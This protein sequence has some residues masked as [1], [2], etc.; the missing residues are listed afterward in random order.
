MNITRTIKN[1]MFI[2]VV[3]L[4]MVVPVLAVSYVGG[5]APLGRDYSWYLAEGSTAWG[6]S[7]YITIANPNLTSVTASVTYMDPN[8]GSGKGDLAG[9]FI[10]LPPSS[11]T[12]VDPRWDL[13]DTDFSTMV[14]CTGSPIAVDRTMTWTGE[15]S[16]TGEGHNSIAATA[17]SGDWYLPEGSSAWGFETWTLVQNPNDTEANVELTY[18]TDAAWKKVRRT[19]P[20]YSR[21]TYPMLT[22]IGEAD[23][24]TQVTSDLPVIV[25]RSMYRND[26]REGSCSIG[27]TTAASDYFL[28]EGTTA[29]GF[30]TYVLVQNPNNT[31]ATVGITYMTPYG[32]AAQPDFVMPPSTRRTVRVNDAAGLSN[33][34]LSTHV[35]ADMPIVAERAMYWRGGPD[36]GEACHASIG[37]PMGSKSF[38]L[39]DGQTSDGHETYTLVQNPGA[40][41]VP[42][43]IT[44]LPEGG[45]TPITFADTV[46]AA[47]RRTYDMADKLQDGRASIQVSVNGGVGDIIAERS[48]YW[49]SRGA[50]DDTVGID[51]LGTRAWPDPPAGCPYFT[52][53]YVLPQSQSVQQL[54]E[55]MSSEHMEY[56]LDGWFFF[57]SLVDD[58]APAHPGGFFISMQRIRVAEDGTDWQLVPAIVG[59]NS[60]TVGGRYVYGG[61]YTLDMAPYVVVESNPWKVEVY[62][63]SVQ[64]WP[65]MTMEL[66]S[67]SM[68]AAG[69]VYRL[70]ADTPD[71]L[72][73]RLEADVTVRDRLGA[74]N[75]GYGT[76]S[77]FPQFITEPQRS[78]IT[79]SFGNSVGTYLEQTGDPMTCQGSYY[80]STPLMDV[81]SF[82]IERDGIPLSSGTRGTM[83]M[84]DIV[85][86]YDE[87]AKEV[88][89]GN[90]SWE[91]FSI[92]L[93]DEDAA[94]MVIQIKSATG[95]L[96]VATLFTDGSGRTRNAA[97]NAVHRW[98]IN[99]IDI[100]PVPGTI[101]KSPTTK[102]KYYQ[103]HRIRLGSNTYPADL[104]IKMVRNNQEIVYKNMIKYEGLATVEG[105][106]GGKPVN[107]TA[108]VELQPVGH[109]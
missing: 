38:L 67:G 92:M 77:L 86:T 31:E 36:D 45:G 1:K 94:I 47:S 96:P 64:W 83:W 75:Q 69:A 74:V 4:L 22:D 90:A 97:R 28:A 59:F 95:T 2:S 80:Y 35:H 39:P 79:G 76:T 106:L 30:D 107:G 25:E 41:D 66:V 32:P 34:D 51:G 42:I 85:Q 84:D 24:S 104:T 56:D 68:G 7:T 87:L 55:W 102:Q 40:N 88:L 62:N 13:G 89:I 8:G 58:T 9:R 82:S 6:F 100:E 91:F 109:Q 72:G 53:D 73:G 99:N 15:G 61:V 11:Q 18:M 19:I 5:A 21:A 71:N 48:V 81:Q 49:N 10:T 63:F 46:P 60:P 57:G 65:I 20:A 105:T 78:E 98:E 23:A 50:G 43:D 44:Y 29:W 14:T 33:T 52:Q 103:E 3:I 108:F 27:A 101:W 70:T 37:I 16:S 54:A 93:P 17:P 12:T 26:R